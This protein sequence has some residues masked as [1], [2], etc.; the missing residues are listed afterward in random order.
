MGIITFEQDKENRRTSLFNIL[1]LFPVPM[2]VFSK[3]GSSIF[4]NNEFLDFFRINSPSDIVE[5]FNVLKDPYINN[6]MGFSDYLKRIFT[7]EILS[8]S[9]VRVPFDEINKRFNIRSNNPL[10]NEIYQD[11]IC[12]PLVEE[13]GSVEYIV[14]V[15]IT[16]HIYQSRIDTIKARNYIDNHWM[17]EF[18]LS[19]LAKHTGLCSHYLARL[20][21]RF[22]GLTPYGYY[23]EVKIKKIK[24]ALGNFDLSISEAFMSCGA[25]YN[26]GIADAFK[27]KT[28]MTPSVYRKTLY[29]NECY[30]SIKTE[31][32]NITN[33]YSPSD[34]ILIKSR[35]FEIA[36]LFPIPIQIFKAN[37]DIIYINDAVLKLWNIMDDSLILG[38][39]NLLRD[40]LVHSY[41]QLS[42]GV[43]RAFQ[44]EI[45]LIQDVR[46]PLESFW[47]WY[48]TRTDAYDI[49]A[50]YTDILNFPVMDDEGQMIYL[51]SVFFTSRIYRGNS[52][53][54]KA[55][56]F[57]E[58]NWRDE[59]DIN[60]IANVACLSPSHLVRLFKTHSG[61][62]PHR[63]Y[64]DIKIIKLKTALR[65]KNLSIAEAFLS[66]GFE[67]SSN[68]SRFF[69]THVGMTPS[70]YRK[71]I[72]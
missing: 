25:D 69:K 38:S 49:E 59:F 36:K 23:Q 14:S 66:C 32:N 51:V 55:R 8:L 64:L 2:E 19:E 7:G 52:E 48:K 72:L 1:N 24:E 45:V 70:Q 22:M 17:D 57:I 27:R 10:D 29:N 11:I 16:K 5:R 54:A 4:V 60:R 43:N 67:Y 3:D 46:V 31:L 40:Q 44:G 21:K 65:D 62:T 63:Y 37:G 41:P 9:D 50:I 33:G 58:N 15:F 56:E 6:V 53:V 18:D 26:G 47:E 30:N 12:F 35:I 42:E 20:F 39:Y 61:V 34:N 28:G 71:S 68:H 13:E